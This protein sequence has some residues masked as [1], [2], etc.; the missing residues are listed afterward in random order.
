VLEAKR[1]LELTCVRLAA[2]RISAPDVARLRR[3]VEE[4]K[5]TPEEKRRDIGE[6]NLHV[7][8]AELSG[9]PAMRLFVEV[10]TKLA[11]LHAADVDVRNRAHLTYDAHAEIAEAVIAGDVALASHAMSRHLDE[12]AKVLR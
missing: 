10:L 12:L 9:N 8:L 7:L 6:N 11:A 5:S 4:E 3:A 2:E 1:A